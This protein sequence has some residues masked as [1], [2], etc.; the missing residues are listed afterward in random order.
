M[1]HP[2]RPRP[3]DE[4][5]AELRERLADDLDT[6]GA[7]AAIDARICG[8]AAATVTAISAIDALLGIRLTA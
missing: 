4:S 7:I 2:G 8:G 6:P 3:T 1:C 5:Q